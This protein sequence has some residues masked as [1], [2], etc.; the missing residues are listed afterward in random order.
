MNCGQN[1][2]S[3]SALLC[4]FYHLKLINKSMSEKTDGQSCLFRDKKRDVIYKRSIDELR[5]AGQKIEVVLKM[6]P[7]IFAVVKTASRRFKENTT[8]ESTATELDKTGCKKDYITMMA[9]KP[10]IKIN[11]QL[12][13]EPLPGTWLLWCSADWRYR[14]LVKL[15]KWPTGK[16]KHWWAPAGLPE[17]IGW[18]KAFIS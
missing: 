5:K 1:K 8:I 7:S 3:S 13:A 15:P 11:G 10:F 12:R 14:I 4:P 2:M 18:P 16:V 6:L 17:C 9:I